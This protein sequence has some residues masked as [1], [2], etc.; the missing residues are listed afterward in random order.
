M[1]IFHC[2]GFRPLKLGEYF[3]RTPLILSQ[4]G[5]KSLVVLLD[6][7]QGHVPPREFQQALPHFLGEA[8]AHQPRR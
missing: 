1:R 2:R 6:P 4:I 3:E 7:L 8:E 5:E